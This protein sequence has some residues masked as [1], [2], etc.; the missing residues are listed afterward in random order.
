MG[1]L[2]DFQTSTCTYNNDDDI[3]NKTV[4]IET[5]LLYSLKYKTLNLNAIQLK[6]SSYGLAGRSIARSEQV[7]ADGD[8]M[9]NGTD[10]DEAVP[11]RVCE[12]NEAI[13]FEEDHT[14]HVNTPT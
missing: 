6:E 9:N 13:T 1:N 12:R 5:T 3:N 8:V 2:K 14:E 11:Y 10:D 4:K 7:L